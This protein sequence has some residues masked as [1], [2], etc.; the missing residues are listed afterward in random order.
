MIG[1][2]ES[3]HRLS[4][5]LHD[6]LVVDVILQSLPTSFEL[7]MLNYHMNGLNNMLTKLH[8]TLKMAEV[9]LRKAHGV[10]LSIKLCQPELH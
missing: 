7:F 8:G 2:I 4:F 6:E 3:M 1:Y 5:S 10:T 9:R